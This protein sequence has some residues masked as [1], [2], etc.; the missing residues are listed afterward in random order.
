[1]TIEMVEMIVMVHSLVVG[2]LEKLEKLYEK[3][4]NK[5]LYAINPAISSD[6]KTTTMVVTHFPSLLFMWK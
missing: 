3:A 4:R 5:H 6:G 1:M 2:L